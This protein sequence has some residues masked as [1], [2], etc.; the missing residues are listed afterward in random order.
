[1]NQPGVF[2]NRQTLEELLRKDLDELCAESFE[3][4]LLDQFVKVGR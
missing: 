3:L 4:I 2:Q 1:M